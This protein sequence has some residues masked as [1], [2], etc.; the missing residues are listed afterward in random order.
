ME[1]PGR[2]AD[3]EDAMSFPSFRA[4][5]AAAT[6]TALLGL[7]AL[8]ADAQPREYR[9][10]EQAESHSLERLWQWLTE[11]WSPADSSQPMQEKSIWQGSSSDA[12]QTTSDLHRGMTIDPNG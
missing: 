5:A 7:S 3:S 6:L 1:A 8:R 12:A 11:L 4:A 10:P 2:L 9:V